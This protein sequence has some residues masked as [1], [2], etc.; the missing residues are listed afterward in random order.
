MTI[1]LNSQIDQLAGVGRVLRLK[2]GRLGI[3]T[4]SDLL[5]YFP[6]RYDDYSNLKKIDAL[7]AGEQVTIRGEVE[8][9]ATRSIRR[10]RTITEAL[11]TDDSGSVKIIWFNQPWISNN[12]KIGDQIVISGK[13]TGEYL[14]LCF[15]SPDYEKIYGEQE[16]SGK[17]LPVY[18]ITDGLTQKKIARLISLALPF[19]GE[20]VDHLPVSIIKS[21][22]MITLSQAIKDIHQPANPEDLVAARKRLGF[23]EVFMVRLWAG[24]IKKKMMQEGAYAVRFYPKKTRDLVKG[25]NFTLTDDQRKAAWTIIKNM[26]QDHPMNRLLQGDVGS[27]KTI[28]A[29]LCMYNV[30]LNKMQSVLMAPTEILAIQHYQTFGNLFGGS[31]L[32]IGLLTRGQIAINGEE[33]SK[34]EFLDRCKRRKIDM[35][36]G[37]HAIIQKGI[38]FKK[39]ALVAIDEQH[40][41]GVEQRNVLKKK[42]K[43]TPHF[44]SLTATPIPRSLALTVYGNLDISTIRQK[45]SDRLSITTKVV[46]PN[47][48]QRAYDFIEDQIKSGRQVFIICPLIDQSD[49]IN[50]RSVLKEFDNLSK[51]IFSDFKVDL[52]HGRLKSVEKDRVMTDFSNGKIDVLVSTSVVEVGVDVPNASVMLIEGAERF[53][54]SQLHQF[55]GRV[56]RS[57]HQSYCFLFS[58]SIQTE[59][60]ERLNKLVDNSDGFALAEQDLKFRGG[61]QVYGQKQSGFQR[62]KI[63]NINDWDFIKSVG[64]VATD[65]LRENSLSKYP[66][67]RQKIEDLGYHDHME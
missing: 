63:A 65:F 56:G 51:N 43:V 42:G 28:V 44:L 7:E 34:K 12:I 4:V 58:D 20:I 10:R 14:D 18:S 49:K 23:D 48:R 55:R 5:F 26:E 8:L 25:L 11:L 39:L 60:M 6:F 50:V 66:L 24:L 40:R 62:F 17:I 36:I 2:L 61:G 29:A 27:G 35:V 15:N 59:S 3:N 30:A 16:S 46:A 53:G 1:N 57:T 67:I 9:L 54:L 13:V 21:E 64:L 37:T 52:L 22:K 45:P 31:K 38:D 47:N 19:T 32:Q 41:F 33:C